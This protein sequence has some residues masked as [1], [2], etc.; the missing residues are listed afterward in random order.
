MTRNLF[1]CLSLIA[2]ITSSQCADVNYTERLDGFCAVA[3]KFIKEQP[4]LKDRADVQITSVKRIWGLP[5]SYRDSIPLVDQKK[6][7]KLKEYWVVGISGLYSKK[8]PTVGGVVLFIDGG[9][10]EIIHVIWQS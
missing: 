2:F 3:I 1:V 5:D 4:V 9:N 8:E 10:D 6:F 7:K